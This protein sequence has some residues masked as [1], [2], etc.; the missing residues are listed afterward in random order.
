[1]LDVEARQVRE[2]EN[3]IGKLS[4]RLFRVEAKSQVAD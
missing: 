3:Q 4:E 2:F 1:M